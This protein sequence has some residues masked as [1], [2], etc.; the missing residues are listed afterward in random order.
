MKDGICRLLFCVEEISRS[1]ELLFHTYTPPFVILAPK[2]AIMK[3]R[4]LIPDTDV[5]LSAFIA[6]HAE[7]KAHWDVYDPTYRVGIS[8]LG[9]VYREII[10][11]SYVEFLALETFL[12]TR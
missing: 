10:C 11:Q 4:L 6:Q 2:G 7:D 9:I 12:K 3:T 1:L 5:E 8:Y